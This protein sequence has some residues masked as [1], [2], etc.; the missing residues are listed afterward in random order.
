MDISIQWD[1]DNLKHI[2]TYCNNLAT[3]SKVGCALQHCHCATQ[4]SCSPKG[5]GTVPLDYFNIVMPKQHQC[6]YCGK[7]FPTVTALHIHISKKRSCCENRQRV[8]AKLNQRL[9]PAGGGRAGSV[10]NVEMEDGS[11]TPADHGPPI[12]PNPPTQLTAPGPRGHEK[13]SRW[14][15]AYPKPAGAMKG[16]GQTNFAKVN[17]QQ[18]YCGQDPWASFESQEEWELTQWLLCNVGQ[19]ATDGFLKLPIVSSSHF[20]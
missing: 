7:R 10:D 20:I 9:A 1:G 18:R 13:V 16:V 15:E 17:D 4:C 19:T 14:G 8:L 3:S 12:H 5:L 6:R 11:D 2:S